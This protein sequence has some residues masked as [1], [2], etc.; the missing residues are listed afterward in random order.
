MTWSWSRGLAPV[1]TGVG[2]PACRRGQ[3]VSRFSCLQTHFS[4]G[5]CGRRY[6]LADL[7]RVLDERDFERLAAAVDGRPSDRV[8]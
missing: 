8:W 5:E 1:E 7:V 6:L 2:C 4:C 3:L